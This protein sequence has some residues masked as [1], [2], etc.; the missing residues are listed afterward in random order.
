MF[1]AVTQKMWDDHPEW[2]ER[3]AN[4]VEGR[5]GWRH[6]LNFQNPECFRASMDWAQSFLRSYDW[7]GINIAE[8]NYDA[9]TADYLAAGKF[10]PMNEDVRREFRSKQGFDPIEL[11][12]ANS[13]RFHERNPRALEVFLRYR[14]DVVTEWHR[15]VLTELQPQQREKHW[16]VIVTAMDS[17]HS[18]F[19]RPALGVNSER[20]A[21]LMKDFDFTL[22]V[23]GPA[24]KWAGPPDRYRVFAQ[25]Y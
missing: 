24:E 22:Q 4:G 8:L 7:D 3:A 6:L 20:I 14:E 21:G 16:E 15:K 11:F 25:A 13:P 9:D 23:E 5:P 2:R 12:Q 18:K 17:L 10:I 1:P 19:V